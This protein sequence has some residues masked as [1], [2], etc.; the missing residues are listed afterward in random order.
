MPTLQV[1]IGS[2]RIQDCLAGLGPAARAGLVRRARLA[3]ELDDED[4]L[5]AGLLEHRI[6]RRAHDHQARGALGLEDAAKARFEDGAV[7][8]AL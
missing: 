5:L 4:A 8:E 3:V 1:L 7:L 2:R 6:R